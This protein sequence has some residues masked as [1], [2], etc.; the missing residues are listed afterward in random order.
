[1]E[2]PVELLLCIFWACNHPDVRTIVRRSVLTIAS[3][4]ND[5]SVAPMKPKRAVL[6]KRF[7]AAEI[8]QP[9]P[10]TRITSGI[11]ASKPILLASLTVAQQDP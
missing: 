1:M 4:N 7:D 10:E 2:R 8:P 11:R 5:V 9:A 3:Q 6:E